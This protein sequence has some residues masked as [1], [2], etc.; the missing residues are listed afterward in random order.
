[1]APLAPGAVYGKTKWLPGSLGCD[2]FVPR[3]TPVLAPADCIIEEVLGGVGIS[4]GDE[5]ILSLPDRSWSWR[6]RHTAAT[7]AVGYRARQGEQV[8]TVGD[9]SLEQLGNPPAWSQPMPDRYQ[10]LDLSVNQGTDQFNPQG[11]GGGNYSAFQWLT[12]LGY[13][14]RILARTPGPPDSGLAMEDAISF[15]TPTGRAQP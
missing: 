14:G 4:G 6:Y 2:L 10:H 15:M 13:Q 12:E 5:L 7:H 9:S 8:G 1:V 3:G 11:G